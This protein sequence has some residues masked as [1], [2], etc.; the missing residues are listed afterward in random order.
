MT[1]SLLQS[2][3]DDSGSRTARTDD[4]G[5]SFEGDAKVRMGEGARSRQVLSHRQ[6]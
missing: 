5:F 2:V 6:V 3:F 1:G 4:S